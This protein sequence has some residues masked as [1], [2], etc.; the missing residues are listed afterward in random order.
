M[1]RGSTLPPTYNSLTA[2]H[3]VSAALSIAI[4][5]VF[6]PLSTQI[7]E[8]VTAEA[9]GDTKKAAAF[10]TSSVKII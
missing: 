1:E 7:T 6:S 4:P 5:I 2:V 8:P 9:N 3:L 10:P